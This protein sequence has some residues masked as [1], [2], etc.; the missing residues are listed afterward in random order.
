[1]SNE[2][3]APVEAG[4][5]DDSDSDTEK[6]RK[7]R[8]CVQPELHDKL[9]ALALSQK[10]AE[11]AVEIT[12]KTTQEKRKTDSDAIQIQSMALQGQPEGNHA[13]EENKE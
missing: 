13:E 3:L 6:R 7:R 4:E 5:S 10:S 12:A 2:L 8:G 9:E 1:M 11:I